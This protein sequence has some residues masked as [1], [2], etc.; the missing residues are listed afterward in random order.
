MTPE[1]TRALVDRAEALL[2]TGLVREA[3]AVLRAAVTTRVPEALLLAARCALRDDDPVTARA[4]A[5]EAEAS[6]RAANRSFWVPV[7][8]AIALRAGASGSTPAP[9][10]T[11]T[12][13]RAGTPPPASPPTPAGP[14]T[15]VGAPGPTNVLDPTNTPAP[16]NTPSPSNTSGL[17][18]TPTPADVIAAASAVAAACDE[19]GHHDDAAELRL[20]LLPAEAAARR[21]RGT[22]RSRA[23]GWLARARLAT[24]RRDAVAACRAGLALHDTTTSGELVD[25]ALDHALDSTDARAVL[26][27]GER[28]R[29]A[30]P[31]PTPEVGEVR[32]E[33]RLAR[34]RGD[35]DRVAYLEREV[36]RLSF[37][38]GPAREPVV[39]LSDV[40]GALGDRALLMFISHRGRLV[41]VSVAAGRV[42][43]HDCG[44][45]RTAARHVRAISLATASPAV[46]GFPATAP[47][48]VA[49]LD[50]LLRP[51]GD[52]GLVVVPS[53]ELARLPWA[54]L[55]SARGRAV[56]VAPSAGCWFRA[57]SRP[58]ALGRRL[59]VAGPDLRHA[60]REVESLRRAHGGEFRSTVDGALSGM[61]QADVVHIA[62][63][64]VRQ[65][66]LFSY[67]Q[68]EDGPLHGHDLDS[69]AKVPPIVVLSACESGL[70]RVLL[71]RGARV[72]VESV[73]SVP[74]DR[75][76]DLMIDLHADLAR[77]AQ[78]LAD[79][80]ARHG[81]LGFVCVGA[82]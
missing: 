11:S 55:P 31:A 27:W 52:R 48:A 53:P 2:S 23:A 14:P 73:R 63:H 24:T 35:Q 50:R 70:A 28:R 38:A 51:A 34:V 78:A 69:L 66:E 16:S 47:H 20:A 76:V 26:H 67:L 56:S 59:W 77:P 5:A 45:A 25:I 64:G 15:P 18:N 46:T 62:A 74:D 7:A 9:V 58:L 36:R 8:Q 81:E 22:T 42:R 30:A 17:T 12:P 4:L 40:L 6:F 65:D 71:R 72:V 82:G 33:L 68:L 43:L 79:A 1:R 10:P 32:A 49:E 60:Q 75:V 57:H 29:A 3:N 13:G 21:H 19:H 61:A 44:D 39:P 37:A 41:A 80:Q 54:A